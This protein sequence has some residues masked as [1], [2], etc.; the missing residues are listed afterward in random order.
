MLVEKGFCKDIGLDCIRNSIHKHD[1]SHLG[2]F[3]FFATEHRLRSTY[4]RYYPYQSQ[5]FSL[6][7]TSTAFFHHPP[8][9]LSFSLSVR[10]RFS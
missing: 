9:S 7:F 2:L 10:I 1:N 5:S 6:S 8:P 3:G 4:R